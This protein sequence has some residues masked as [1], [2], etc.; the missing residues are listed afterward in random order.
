LPLRITIP[1]PKV[2]FS[3]YTFCVVYLVI[4]IYILPDFDKYKVIPICEEFGIIFLW[5]SGTN[6]QNPVPTWHPNDIIP[7]FDPYG[8]KLVF[9]QELVY[10]PKTKTCLQVL[11]GC[12]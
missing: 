8:K 2:Y 6:K 12:N 11:D 5:Y 9:K 7:S 3:I 4:T 1:L 10:N